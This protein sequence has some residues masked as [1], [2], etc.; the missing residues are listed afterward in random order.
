[1]DVEDIHCDFDE[2]AYVDLGCDE[3]QRPAG[4]NGSCELRR[5]KNRRASRLQNE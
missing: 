5:K 1:V 2:Q 4:T 3:S